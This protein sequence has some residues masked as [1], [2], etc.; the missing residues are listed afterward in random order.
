MRTSWR[1]TVL[2]TTGAGLL[3]LAA[4]AGL[5]ALIG[6]GEAAASAGLVGGGV[7]LLFLMSLALFAVTQHRRPDWG[8]AVLLASLLLKVVLIGGVLMLAPIPDWLDV[9]WTAVAV[10][11][12]LFVWQAMLVRGV[13][14]M[15]V[16]VE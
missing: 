7:L 16:P 9:V 4:V 2:T 5:G 11:V 6:G 10:V 15:R 3:A 12:L 8:P 13:W 14:K 1:S